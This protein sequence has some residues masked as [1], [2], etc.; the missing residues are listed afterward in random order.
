MAYDHETQVETEVGR[1]MTRHTLRNNMRS[2]PVFRY[3]RK[4]RSGDDDDDADASEAE[5][6]PAQLQSPA[7][8][9]MLC[10]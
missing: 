10:L 8:T 2:S 1:C 3:Q 5:D 4:R 9:N 7:A 6:E